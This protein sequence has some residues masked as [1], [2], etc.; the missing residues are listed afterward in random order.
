DFIGIA[1]SRTPEEPR[2]SGRG[3]KGVAPQGPQRSHPGAWKPR[4]SGRG[5][6]P[7]DHQ[8]LLGVLVGQVAK[9]LGEPDGLIVFDPSSFPKRG[10]HSVGVKRQWCGHWGKVDN[11]LLAFNALLWYYLFSVLCNHKI[12]LM[13]ARLSRRF[14][15]MV[16]QRLLLLHTVRMTWR[17]FPR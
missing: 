8:P 3:G 11:S 15:C 13:S 7:R 9:R 10:T 12:F 1:P 5:G 14:S 6:R 17:W 4:P 16:L 2:R